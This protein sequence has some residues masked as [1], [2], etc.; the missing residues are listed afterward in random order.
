MDRK[1]SIEPIQIIV[2]YNHLLINKVTKLTDKLICT[3]LEWESNFRLIF[4]CFC[5]KCYSAT[6]H[7]LHVC[8]RMD[9]MSVY[10]V[11][12]V[13]HPV[14]ATGGIQT[15]ILDLQYSCRLTG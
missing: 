14:Q 11:L 13:V 15:N 5:G 9:C 3:I 10:Y 1:V 12:A 8:C 4:D 2:I 6:V 7:V